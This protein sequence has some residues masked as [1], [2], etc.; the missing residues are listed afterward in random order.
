MRV[1]YSSEYHPAYAVVLGAACMSEPPVF[2]AVSPIMLLHP[3]MFVCDCPES[4]DASRSQR[5]DHDAALAATATGV[6]ETDI[7][8]HSL[9]ELRTL[10]R[11]HGPPARQRVPPIATPGYG[12]A[13]DDAERGNPGQEH[14]SWR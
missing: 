5:C 13:P 9:R 3:V 2:T 11:T 8:L 4:G 12:S 6:C 10:L 1:Q 14:G 7:S